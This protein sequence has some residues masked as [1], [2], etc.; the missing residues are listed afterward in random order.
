[1]RQKLPEEGQHITALGQSVESGQVVSFAQIETEIAKPGFEFAATRGRL[2]ALDVFRGATIAAMILVNNP[3]NSAACWPLKHARWNGWT[4][5]DLVF[6]FFLFIVG[7][8]LVFSFTSRLR[9]GDSRR[10]LVLHTLRRSATIFAIG[11][12]LNGL[13][14]FTLATW[15]IPG[16]LQRIA[17]AYLAAALITLYSR[18]NTRI[19]WIAVLLASYW[20]LMRFVPV[21][22]YGIPTQDIPLLHPNA[23]LA[24]YL[25]RKLMFGHL[26]EG[27]RDP[28][29]VL[30]TLPA[31]ATALS[32]VLTGEWLR[33]NRS[34]KQKA[35]GMLVAG[36]AGIVAGKL[37]GIW[38][39]INKNLWTSSYVLFTAGCALVCLA[40][41]YWAVDV[42]LS[43][44]WWTRPFIIFGTNAIAAYVISEV[45]GGAFGWKESIFQSTFARLGS[46]AVA[47]LLYSLAVVG[48]CF[49]PVWWMYRRRIFLKV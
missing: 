7:V 39:P 16:V 26:W 30:S 17:I 10:A 34:P 23:N 21:P 4:P 47:S 2:V 35:A 22:G 48:V 13:P 12:L 8:S 33:S 6:P 43:R 41:C 40:I 29:G 3:G 19:A 37:G 18:T 24:A 5:T 45:L 44:G 42:K 15:R 27:T 1:V 36:V 14:H 9:R 25:D 11:L 46:P 32:G 31:I 38:F 20:A 49:L 28:E